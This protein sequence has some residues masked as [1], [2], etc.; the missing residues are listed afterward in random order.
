MQ[1]FRPTRL[2]TI[3]DR[4]PAPSW[5]Q[6]NTPAC[7]HTFMETTNLRHRRVAV[8]LLT[9]QNVKKSICLSMLEAGVTHRRLPIRA[10]LPSCWVTTVAFMPNKRWK[11]WVSVREHLNIMV[12]STLTVPTAHTHIHPVRELHPPTPK[13]RVL[14]S[15]YWVQPN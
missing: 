9:Q 10:P 1:L 2:L 15:G 13:G 14:G 6:Y 5:L 8:Q 4:Q 3:V 11:F 7:G 12:F